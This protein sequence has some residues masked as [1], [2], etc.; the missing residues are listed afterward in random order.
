MRFVMDTVCSFR[1]KLPC[2][3]AKKSIYKILPEESKITIIGKKRSNT[4][5]EMG[6]NKSKGP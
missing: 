4:N 1:R 6:H 5:K 2:S 3:L